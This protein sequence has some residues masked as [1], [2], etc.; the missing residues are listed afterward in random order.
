M[1]TLKKLINAR[2]VKVTVHAKKK[3]EKKER[4]KREKKYSVIILLTF[5]WHQNRIM[6][7]KH[8]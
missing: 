4:K 6:V 5:M 3:K 2:E 8:K 7:V 1:L